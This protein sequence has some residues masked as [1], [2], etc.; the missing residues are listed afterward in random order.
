[1]EA[2]WA[3]AVVVSERVASTTSIRGSAVY[4]HVGVLVRVNRH[5]WILEMGLI[6]AMLGHREPALFHGEDVG[7]GR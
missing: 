6:M 5:G 2:R 4:I 3:G 1:M 7:N